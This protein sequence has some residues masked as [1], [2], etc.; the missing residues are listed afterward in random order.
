MPTVNVPTSYVD[1][2]DPDAVQYHCCFT[3]IHSKV[4][5]M[6]FQV[7]F[8]QKKRLYRPAPCALR[9]HRCCTASR[10]VSSFGSWKSR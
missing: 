5:S 8:V 7:V 3:N 9:S 6:S 2:F 1:E 10:A 4:C